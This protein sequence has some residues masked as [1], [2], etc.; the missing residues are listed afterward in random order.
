MLDMSDVVDDVD[1]APPQPFTILRSTAI[2]NNGV[3]ESVTTQITVFGKVERAGPK[4]L[5]MMAEADRVGAVMNFWATQPMYV[6]RGKAPEPSTFSVAPAGDFPGTVYTLPSAPP[7]GIID[8]FL[9]GNLLNPFTDYT[10]DGVTITLGSSTSGRDQLFATW[11]ITANVA[12]AASDILVYNG[13]QYRIV[14]GVTHYPGSGYW[15]AAATR[16]SMI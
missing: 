4:Q 2:W 1:L 5:A 10:L 9:N 13:E 11:P 6:T 14:E 3:F 12:P 8:L 7:G 16:L 15:R